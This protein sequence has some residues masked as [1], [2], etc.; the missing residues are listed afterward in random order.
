[1]LGLGAAFGG[2][3]DVFGGD[4]SK[5]CKGWKWTV[6]RDKKGRFLGVIRDGY[7]R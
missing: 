3:K 1:M 7:W 5:T 4:D 2:E 6:F